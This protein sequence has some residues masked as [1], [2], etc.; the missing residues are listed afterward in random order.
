MIR[1]GLEIVVVPGNHTNLLLEPNAGIVARSLWKALESAELPVADARP[2]A[3]AFS[4]RP[5]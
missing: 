5:S 2:N 3:N 1:G 4:D